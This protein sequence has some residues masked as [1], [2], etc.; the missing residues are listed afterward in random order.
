MASCAERRHGRKAIS[1]DR[2]GRGPLSDAHCCGCR[3]FVQGMGKTACRRCGNC[4]QALDLCGDLVL[5]SEKIEESR[6]HVWPR[7]SRQVVARLGEQW[8]LTWGVLTTL[9]DSR[10][11]SDPPS[12]TPN[13]DPNRYS[14]EK[15]IPLAQPT[16]ANSRPL[17]AHG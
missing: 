15:G 13:L 6:G 7:A 8:V 1:D 16:E 5:V 9:D 17:G 4:L 2:P 12:K 14:D 10:R 3:T 11:S